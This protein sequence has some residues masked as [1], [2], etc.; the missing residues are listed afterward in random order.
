MT[1]PLAQRTGLIKPSPTLAVTSKAAELKA[2]G[3][4]VASFGAGEPDFPTP[5]HI[6][7]AA[8]KA[9]DDG[10]TRYTDVAGLIELRRSLAAF[11]E[12]TY[13]LDYAPDELLVT[14]GGK[15]GL[16]E[17]FMCLVNPGD[18]VIIP[19]PYWV[20]YPPQVEL[21]GGVPVFVESTADT[22]FKVTPEQVAAKC[23]PRTRVLVINSPSNPTGAVYTPE[24]LRALA[25]LAVERD[26]FVISD[27][28]Y[29]A[30]LYDGAEFKSFPTL[31]DGLRDRVAVASGWSKTYSMTGWRLGWVA[32]PRPLIKAMNNLQS[33]TTS[34]VTAAAQIAAK[35]ATDGPHDF[36]GEWLRVF[37]RRRKLCVDGLN[38]IPGVRCPNPK[39]AFYVF[40]DFRDVLHLEW[41]GAPL[42]DGLR[43]A[44]YLLTEALTA[45]VPGE[46]FG[47]K[48]CVR[49]SYA[50]SDA[51]IEKGITRIQGAI[52]KLR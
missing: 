30:L 26:L 41:N 27:E 36:I 3:K 23:T 31:R 15:F 43:L 46:A 9:I 29:S 51:V 25:D 45:V 17:L 37:D 18:E 34:N 50:T 13:G 1:F 5:V 32:G 6:R 44:E 8:K 28:I 38:A 48:G 11:L 4:D 47:A 2:Q 20:S 7:E 52:A 22:D 40:A 21:A 35:A 33:Q 14:T 19:A 10:Y 16:Y 49:L 42:G 39:G 24:E 12:R